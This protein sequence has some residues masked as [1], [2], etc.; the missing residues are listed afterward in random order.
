MDEVKHDA[1]PSQLVY[2][3]RGAWVLLGETFE[4]S[5]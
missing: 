1:C 3:A 5:S 2:A 4:H